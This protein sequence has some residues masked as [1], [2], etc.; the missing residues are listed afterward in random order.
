MA[1]KS[2]GTTSDKLVPV[3]FKL[4]ESQKRFLDSMGAPASAFV[5]KLI[6]SQMEGHAPKLAELKK[7]WN[8][9]KFN[10]HA[11]EL[12]I[13]EH[14]S[15]TAKMQL[16]TQG[17]EE[18]IAK[19]VA[20]LFED[21]RVHHRIKKLQIFIRNNV[22]NI[23][24]RLAGSGAMLVTEVELTDRLRAKAKDEGVKLLD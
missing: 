17:R 9:I 15:L 21:L 12:Q 7:E 16:S 3:Q 23:N 22:T 4:L 10:L 19:H 13:A 2:V 5:R 8:Q 14:E 11:K 18:S 20:I 24:T 6:A 1:N